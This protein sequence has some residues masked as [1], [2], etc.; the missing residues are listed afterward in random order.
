M[1]GKR[2]RKTGTRGCEWKIEILNRSEEKT[3][4]KQ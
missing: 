4:S 1:D 2:E 3:V